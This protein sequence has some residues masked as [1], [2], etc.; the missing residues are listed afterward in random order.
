MKPLKNNHVIIKGQK[1]G[2][3]VFC[4][5]CNTQFVRPIKDVGKTEKCSTCLVD[6]ILVEGYA[7]KAVLKTKRGK[8]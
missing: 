7:P 3:M 8:K 5:S 1:H 4:G 6:T 2:V